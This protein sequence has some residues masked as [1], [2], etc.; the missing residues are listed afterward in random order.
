[1]S[2]CQRCSTTNA[3]GL[4]FRLAPML[5]ALVLGIAG[6]AAGCGGSD[7]DVSALP[8]A[9]VEA[10]GSPYCVTAR[11]WA[12]HE[13][14]EALPAGAIVVNETISHRGDLTQLLDKLRPGAFF[15]ASYG[16]LGMG[17]GTALGV[18]HARRDRPVVLTLG[19]GSFYYNA[20]PAAFGCCQEHDLPLLV[21]LFD[22]AGYFS[23]KNDVVREYPDGHAVRSNRFIGTSIT[24][25]P[26]YALLARAF[27]GHGEKVERPADVRAALQRGL[28]ALAQGKLALVHLVLDPVNR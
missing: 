21:V 14:N 6:T 10:F 8:D 18:K 7:D 4:G 25:Q 26:D 22:N 3:P 16:G 19:D 23:Q 5:A 11:A 24:P 1:M 28:D 2:R 27:G 13:L 17:L 9:Q 15:E 20:V 12:A